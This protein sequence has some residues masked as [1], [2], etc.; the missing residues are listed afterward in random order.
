MDVAYMIGDSLDRDSSGVL[1]L[2]DIVVQAYAYKT[3]PREGKAGEVVIT[4]CGL[5]DGVMKRVAQGDVTF[6]QASLFQRL[7]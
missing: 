6:P 1:E 2:L 7:H 3:K 4:V 5:P